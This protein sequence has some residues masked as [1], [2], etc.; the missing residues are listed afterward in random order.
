MPDLIVISLPRS[1][2]TSIAEIFR[3]YGAINE[4]QEQEYVTF[5]SMYK[6]GLINQIQIDSLIHKRY[7]NGNLII[8]AASFNF[9]VI[10]RLKVLFPHVKY[11][12]LRRDLESWANSFIKMLYYYSNKFSHEQLNMPEWM[13]EYG[14][15]Y[16]PIFDWQIIDDVYNQKINQNVE[17][18]LLDLANT[19]H[20]ISNLELNST[21]DFLE[22][23]TYNLSNNIDKIV[24][25]LGI[26]FDTSSVQKHFNKAKISG[27]IINQ[28]Y[29]EILQSL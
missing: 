3:K 24:E 9:M 10:D 17:N 2:T 1:G 8:D 14:Y 18:F 21:Y 4:F 5:Y 15:V 23:E 27:N 25:F 16:S 6:K 20:E 26:D 13:T 19:W 28:H 7:Q 29:K 11:L 22:L 12:I